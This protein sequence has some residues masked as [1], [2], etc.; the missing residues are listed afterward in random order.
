MILWFHYYCFIIPLA[1][2]VSKLIAQVAF[3]GCKGLPTFKVGQFC[4]WE[5]AVKW[6]H[7][8][9]KEMWNPL[10]ASPFLSEFSPML[11]FPP[12]RST[13]CCF[14]GKCLIPK[15]GSGWHADPIIFH[16]CAGRGDFTTL[17]IAERSSSAIATFRKHISFCLA[18]DSEKHLVDIFLW[19]FPIILRIYKI[20]TANHWQNH[21][22]TIFWLKNNSSSLLW[23]LPVCVSWRQNFNTEQDIGSQPFKGA[24]LF[25]CGVC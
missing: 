24:I 13:H 16:V 11:C 18:C 20:R 3:I 21:S 25:L 5:N 7:L 2:Q 22:F 10:A 9:G 1:H 6:M 15:S 8:C 12:A 14:E 19:S 23:C 4:G 17:M